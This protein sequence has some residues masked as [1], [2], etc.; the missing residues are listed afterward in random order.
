MQYDRKSSRKTW[1][2]KWDLA[3]ARKA[4]GWNDN[5]ILLALGKVSDLA[6]QP[7]LYAL[8]AGTAVVGVLRGDGRLSGR[9]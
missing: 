7:P 3:A 6:D 5:K 4:G 1:I 9:V 2:E 8:C